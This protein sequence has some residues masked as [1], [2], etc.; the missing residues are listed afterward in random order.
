MCKLN[1]KIDLVFKKIFGTEQNKNV[2]KSLI[3]S[4]L[5]KDEQIVEVTIKNPYNEADFVGDKLSVV[6]IKATDEKGRWYDIEI[7]VKE[8]KFYG[9]RAIF[10]LSEIYSNQLSE[11]DSY[12]KLRKTIIISIL[13]FNYFTNDKRYFRRCSYKDFETGEFYPELNFADL[14]FVELKKFDNELKNIKTTLDR[15]I[16]FLNKATEYD[17]ETIPNELRE[18][19]IIQAFDTIETMS[20]SVKEREYYEAEKKVMRDRDAQIMTAVENAVDNAKI[21]FARIMKSKGE[22]I[23]KIIE[24]SGLSK[25]QIEKL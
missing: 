2:L 15:W 9:K 18:P 3:N 17:R 21:E 8:Q 16:T 4:V 22:P 14:Y 23:E 13:D 20:L 19:E 25:E 12:D 24:Y 7:Q 10:Y 5:P 11:S 1:P 6:D